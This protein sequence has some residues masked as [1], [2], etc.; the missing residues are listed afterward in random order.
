MACNRPWAPSRAAF[1]ANTREAPRPSAMTGSWGCHQPKCLLLTVTTQMHDVVLFNSD[2]NYFYC[3][4]LG[5]HHKAENT[6]K[7]PFLVG[8]ISK[9]MWLRGS[10]RGGNTDRRT[11]GRTDGQAAGGVPLPVLQ[12]T[13]W[14]CPCPQSRSERRKHKRKE[15]T[16]HVVERWHPT[17]CG[18]ALLK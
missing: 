14:G 7:T 18:V 1:H 13:G 2:S 4:G 6:L 3:E 17:L 11:G 8:Q 16:H 5:K 15:E 12:T 9:Q 10:P